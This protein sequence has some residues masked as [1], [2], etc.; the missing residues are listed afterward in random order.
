MRRICVVLLMVC[1]IFVAGIGPANAD[2]VAVTSNGSPDLSRMVVNNGAS[3][4][5]VKLYGVGGKDNVRW[6]LVRLKGTD[7]V[8]YEAKVGWYSGGVWIKSLY[9]G[10]AEISCGNYTYV[11]NGTAAFWRVSVPR[12]CLGRLTNRLKAYSEH[13]GPSPTPGAA[14][15]SPWVARG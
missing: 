4:V 13:V 2:K 3:T 7:G 12:S 11:W 5:V 6:S 1:G 14:G 8:T 10:N 15:W 9:R